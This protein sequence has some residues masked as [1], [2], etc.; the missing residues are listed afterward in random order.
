MQTYS[1]R[2][3]RVKPTA[4]KPFALGITGGARL[5]RSWTAAG[6]CFDLI[7]DTAWTT[8]DQADAWPYRLH[9]VCAGQPESKGFDS[10]ADAETYAWHIS[11]PLPA[12]DAPREEQNAAFS[13]FIAVEDMEARRSHTPSDETWWAQC[14]P[15]PILPVC[16]GAPLPEPA[17]ECTLSGRWAYP[18][19]DEDLEDMEPAFRELSDDWNGGFGHDA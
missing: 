10:T 14:Q 1:A 17:P 8:R 9:W 5:V 16:G 15:A 3:R 4:R 12:P 6:V 2:D 19:E 18:G 7:E 11:T 13:A